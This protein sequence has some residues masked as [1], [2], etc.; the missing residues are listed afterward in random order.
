MKKRI[1][2]GVLSI[3][4][5]S[6]VGTTMGVTAYADTEKEVVAVIDGTTIYDTND[7][8]CENGYSYNQILNVMDKVTDCVSSY[9]DASS[10]YL[11]RVG[12]HTV[13]DDN[14]NIRYTYI[15]VATND[16]DS[17]EYIDKF[18][19]DNGY[20]D[21]VT[22]EYNPYITP[23]QNAVGI[24]GEDDSLGVEP[25]TYS[26]LSLKGYIMGLNKEIGTKFDL[27]DDGKINT[28]DLLILKKTILTG[29]AE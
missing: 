23:V 24:V 2:T 13:F 26:L 18:C 19:S 28:L 8:I 29:V 5:A 7:D 9:P 12:T 11:F 21:V 16:K 14:H 20:S 3:A 15:E 17:I 10:D 6:V 27:N 25:N 1:L 22:V 4:L